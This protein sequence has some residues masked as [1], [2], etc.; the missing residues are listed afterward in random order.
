MAK[1]STQLEKR[2]I[3]FLRK[4]KGIFFKQ[5]K[6]SKNILVPSSQYSSF[7]RILRQLSEE[8][9]IERGKRNTYRIPDLSKNVTGVISFSGRGFG[10]VT[11]EDGEEIF[12]GAYDVATAFNHDKVLVERYKKQT[13]KRPEGKVLKVLKRSNE[14]IFG[15]LEK[16]QSRWIVIP[17]SPTPPV[18]IVVIGG[19]KNIREGQMVELTRLQWDSPR[20]LPRGEIKQIL[21]IP[22]DPRDDI[23]ILKKMFRLPDDFPKKVIDEVEHFQL[24][25]LSKELEY[26]LDF[27]GKEIFTVDPERARDY[28][29]AISLEKDDAGNWVL[30]VHIAD[31]S[32]Y[33]AP[34]TAVDCEARKRGTSVYFYENVIPMLPGYLSNELCCLQPDKDK[35]TLSLIIKVSESGDILDFDVLPGVI[36]SKKRFTY[37]EVQNILNSGKGPHWTTLEKM[38]K[39]SRI[40]YKKRSEAG[41]ID[42]D[43][44]EPMFKMSDDGVPYE[45]K[46]TERLESHRIIEEFMLLA[47]R[48]IAEW[49]AFHRKKERLPFIYRIHEPPTEDSITGLYDILGRLGMSYTKPQNFTPNDLRLILGDI[50]EMPFKNFI[51]KISLRSMSKAVYSHRPLSHFGLSFRYYTHFTSPI[52]RYPDLVVHRLIKTYKNSFS[53]DDISF[54]RHSLPKVAK[55]CSENEIRAIEVEREYIKIKQIRFLVDKIGKWF[56]GIITGVIEFGFFVELSDFLIDGLVHVRTLNDDYYI[57]DENNHI[58]RGK[59]YKRTFRLGDVVHVKISSVSVQD[60][61]IDFEWGE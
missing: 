6:I 29:D 35:L 38:K 9:K 12:V 43:I 56:V 28:D 51:E 54:Y 5:R 21:G 17:E 26:R 3:T 16:K 2:V 8:G 36:R 46:P 49:I 42:F 31:V 30:G 40:L 10:F 1:N 58:L 52:R 11:T 60:R 34:G 39:L 53:K 18:N 24:P 57:F 27:R 55:L 32:Q 50:K 22:D 48:T 47:N 19:F 25:D 14:P 4:N 41:S 13:G 7:K 45:I 15:T 20:T 23:V 33:I 44:P 59:K 61:R 37:T